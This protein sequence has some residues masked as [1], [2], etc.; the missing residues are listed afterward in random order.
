MDAALFI[1]TALADDLANEFKNFNTTASECNVLP[2]WNVI[3][4]G[5]IVDCC[6]E[7]QDTGVFV[8]PSREGLPDIS[9]VDIDS[10]QFPLY[11]HCHFFVKAPEDVEDNWY[12]EEARNLVR[13]SLG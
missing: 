9:G 13:A 2:L 5:S 1:S 10:L 12:K 7:Y 3:I 6:D 4:N 11:V 8:G